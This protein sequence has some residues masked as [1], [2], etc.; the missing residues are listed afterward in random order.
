MLYMSQWFYFMED[1]QNK[2]D[3]AFLKGGIAL[4][5]ILVTGFLFYTF[6]KFVTADNMTMAIINLFV[7]IFIGI[8]TIILLFFKNKIVAKYPKIVKF[9]RI[10]KF[11]YI[12]L[13]VLYIALYCFSL[14]HLNY[15]DKTQETIDFINSKKITLDD[16]MGKNLPPEPDQKLNGSTI[17]GIDANKNFI[18]DDVELAIFKN[19]PNSAKTRAAELQ[20]AQSMQLELTQVHSKETMVAGMKKSDLAYFC[21]GDIFIDKDVRIQDA[22]VILDQKEKE[23]RS[24][25]LNTDLRK[26]KYS[27]IYEKYMTGYASPS[28]DYCDI[29]P[30]SLAN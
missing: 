7:S 25:I 22:F 28:G 14:W 19:Y 20:Y 10:Y 23:M 15:L 8:P 18:R 29:K 6:L 1:N 12:I 4:G 27:D 9:W 2:K 11:F 26:S 16:V 24:L 30:S 21:F 5:K 3:S 13:V 17:A